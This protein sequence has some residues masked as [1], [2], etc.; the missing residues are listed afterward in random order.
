MKSYLIACTLAV[1]LIVGAGCSEQ[2]ADETVVAPIAAPVSVDI[3]AASQPTAVAVASQTGE[4][5]GPAPKE[6]TMPELA[7][8]QSAIQTF[9]TQNKRMPINV[10]ELVE[11]GAI[12]LPPLPAGQIY[13]I[14]H[15]TKQI[16]I[17]GGP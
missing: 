14:D 5:T 2:S 11:S 15:A 6:S 16:K 9:E 4:V 1:A 12:K 13:Y 8:I 10:H 3:G 17:G 7:P